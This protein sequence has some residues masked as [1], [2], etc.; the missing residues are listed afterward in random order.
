[1]TLG[2]VQISP[3]DFLTFI[4]IFCFGYFLTG[5]IKNALGT[6]ILPRTSLD[7]GAQDAIVAGFGYVGIFLTAVIAI[8]TAGIDL[9]N[10]AIV[11]GALST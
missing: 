4:F 5:F 2:E 10:L 6:S 7:L 9:S 3:S 11:A 1:M 8:T